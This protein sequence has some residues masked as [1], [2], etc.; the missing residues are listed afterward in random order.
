VPTTR[1]SWPPALVR[2]VAP[3]LHVTLRRSRNKV[4]C[5]S[6]NIPIQVVLGTTTIFDTPLRSVLA[7]HA[8]GATDEG[9][10]DQS[11]AC[12]RTPRCDRTH[13]RELSQHLRAC[14]SAIGTTRV[15]RE[16]P[17]LCRCLGRSRPWTKRLSSQ[18]APQ[19]SSSL[20][21]ILRG[22]SAIIAPE[23]SKKL[24]VDACSARLDGLNGID[25]IGRTCH[26]RRGALQA[27][28][29]SRGK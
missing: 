12:S 22:R 5:P 20:F 21:A 19:S 6:T 18:R 16:V 3:R 27:C 14:E 17:R 4:Y 2:P 10:G 24:A 1:R 26:I 23:Q 25:R 29:P 15:C 9:P 13:L 11:S 7:A 28:R 8:F